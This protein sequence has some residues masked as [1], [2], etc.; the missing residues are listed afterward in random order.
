MK[1]EIQQAKEVIWLNPDLRPV[2][3]AGDCELTMADIDD[4]RRYL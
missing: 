2:A 4:A 3:E 1:E